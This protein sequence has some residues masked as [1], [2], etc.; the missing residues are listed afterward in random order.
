MHE[1]AAFA[2]DFD[3]YEESG[4]RR[5]T[6]LAVMHKTP[7]KRSRMK[8]SDRGCVMM[9]RGFAIALIFIFASGTFSVLLRDSSFFESSAF[10]EPQ[11]QKRAPGTLTGVVLGP[12]DKPVAHANVSYQSSAGRSPHAVRTDSNGRFTISKLKADNYDVRASAKGIFSEW[13]KNV[14]LQS[15]Q[16]KSLTLRLIYSR[17]DAKTLAGQSK[18]PKS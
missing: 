1:G 8:L 6:F 10:A 9:R 4:L 17:Q 14:S 12:D 5:S 2:E 13:E 3:L 7:A 18:K 16:S 15:G 11:R